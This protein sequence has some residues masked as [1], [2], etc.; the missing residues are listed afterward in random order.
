MYCKPGVG[1]M[2]SRKIPILDVS[3]NF[4]GKGQKWWNFVFLPRNKGNKFFWWKFRREMENCKIQGGLASSLPTPIPVTHD[5]NPKIN[6][7]AVWTKVR[8]VLSKVVPSSVNWPAKIKSTA[9]YPP[10]FQRTLAL[11]INQSMMILPELFDRS[12]MLIPHVTYPFSFQ[13]KTP[14]CHK[15]VHVLNSNMIMIVKL[16]PSSKL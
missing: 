1:R 15:F 9:P 14:A 12:F 11:N 3:N 6:P 5:C 8:S 2:F 13:D 7:F 4:F 16:K 10:R